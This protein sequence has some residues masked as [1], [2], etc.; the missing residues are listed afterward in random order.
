MFL[1]F[2]QK[3]I[4]SF[5]WNTNMA[6]TPIVLC[7]NALLF[8]ELVSVR[9]FNLRLDPILGFHTFPRD[10]KDNRHSGQVNVPNKRNN[11]NLF[12]K[13]TPAWPTWRQVRRSMWFDLLLVCSRILFLLPKGVLSR[14]EFRKMVNQD[15]ESFLV[16]AR[17]EAWLFPAWHRP[18]PLLMSLFLKLRLHEQ[19]SCG[20]FHLTFLFASASPVYTRIFCFCGNFYLTIFI[21]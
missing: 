3:N 11:Q 13:S 5:V 1:Y 15:W 10:T 4:I 16:L 8:E 17:R 6:A 2:R 7:E 19:F 18:V 9:H 20:N 21:C 12:V 14:H